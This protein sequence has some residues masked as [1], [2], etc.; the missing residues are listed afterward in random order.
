MHARRAQPRGRRR[1]LLLRP[2][3]GGSV[4]VKWDPTRMPLCE[5]V[6][7]DG[8]SRCTRSVLE[9]V[10]V[11]PG[12]ERGLCR[13]HLDNWAN[14]QTLILPKSASKRRKMPA[15][16][17]RSRRC[18]GRH[19]GRWSGAAHAT[20]SPNRPARGAP[21]NGGGGLRGNRARP[22][23]R[24]SECDEDNEGELPAVPVHVQPSG[25]RLGQRDP[26]ELRAPRSRRLGALGDS[27]RARDRG[28]AHAR[29]GLA[30]VERA[31]SE[32]DGAGSSV[33][34]QAAARARLF[35]DLEDEIREVRET[36]ASYRDGHDVSL[37]RLK[38]AELA[39]D[40][41]GRMA[42]L[43]APFVGMTFTPKTAFGRDRSGL[44]PT[45]PSRRT[46]RTAA[47]ARK[48]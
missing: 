4:P 20:R 13:R 35:G 22:A 7:A 14:R 39:V 11:A 12:V 23:R 48:A 5:G 3:P 10:A 36:I 18:A 34:D 25:A 41:W 32:A 17:R 43:L 31:V 33:P 6:L 26:R 8:H 37:R 29:D 21:D 24:D 40:Y 15:F 38:H 1:P 16:V 44:G 27:Q 19:V 46:E 45:T 9:H 30:A 47:G 42:Q 2:R 28:A